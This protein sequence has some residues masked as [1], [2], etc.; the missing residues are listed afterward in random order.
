MANDESVLEAI[1]KRPAMY[2]GVY[3]LSALRHFISGYSFALD[4]HAI[5][6]ASDPL[7]LPRDF[8]DWVAYRLR[9]KESTSG[10]CNMILNRAGSEN[11]AFDRFFTLLDEYR[12]RSP[13][14]VAKLVGYRKSYLRTC[15]DVTEQLQYPPSISL[16]TYTDD[17]GF[18]ASSDTDDEFPYEGF[19]S[20]IDWF[21][22][23][24]GAKRALLTIVDHEW[25][26]GIRE[27]ESKEAGFI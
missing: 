5:R 4:T 17:P 7:T 22:M 16:V 20:C 25:N 27:G 6:D 21:E 1:R 3:S 23:C 18:F 24:T 8:H 11:D 15:G 19:F 14:L 26:Y 12:V 9:F 13:H 2:L 10:W